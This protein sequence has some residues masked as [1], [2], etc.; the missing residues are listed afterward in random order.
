MDFQFFL[1]LWRNY[2]DHISVCWFCHVDNIKVWLRHAHFLVILD[3]LI[4]VLVQH[5]YYFRV[6]Q[7]SCHYD[8]GQ[9][10]DVDKRPPLSQIFKILIT[11]IF[12]SIIRSRYIMRLLSRC[13]YRTYRDQTDWNPV[14]FP[15]KLLS[16]NYRG[17]NGGEYNGEARSGGHQDYISEP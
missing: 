14:D 16:Q 4:K 9:D 5:L 6:E 8:E 7:G 3:R 17:E 10:Y 15:A 2:L 13:K 12:H 11:D 1:S